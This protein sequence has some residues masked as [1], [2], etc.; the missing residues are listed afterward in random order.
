VLWD[1]LVFI[2]PHERKAKRCWQLLMTKKIATKKGTTL[3]KRT[4]PTKIK[5][6]IVFDLETTTLIPKGI[7]DENEKIEEIKK[8]RIS[9]LCCFDYDTNEYYFYTEKNIKDFLD[10]VQHID[11]IVG[12]N[13]L[14]FDYLVLEKYGLKNSLKDKSI[15]I[16]DMIRQDTGEWISLDALSRANLGRG[17]LVKGK[18]M[19]TADLVTLFD[20]CKGDVLNTKE[21]FE[22]YLNKKLK[23]KHLKGRRPQIYFVDDDY[24][25]LGDGDGY[26]PPDIKCPKC[27]GNNFEKFDELRDGMGDDEM[28]E[29]QLAEYMAGTWGTLECLD[30]GETV[31]YEV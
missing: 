26:I 30:C 14:S 12:Y 3:S 11:K 28:T 13:I 17:K 9:V 10:K 4:I 8:L 2:L 31:D 22:L 29:G 18:D 21:L 25:E 15:D 16:F 23:Y 1:G 27:G 19:V 5:N 6:T 7:D 20:G 24:V